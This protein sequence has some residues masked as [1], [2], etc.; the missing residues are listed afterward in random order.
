MEWRAR[1][2]ARVQ[3]IATG[4]RRAGSRADFADFVEYVERHHVVEVERL[5]KLLRAIEED[6]VPGLPDCPVHPEETLLLREICLDERGLALEFQ[7]LVVEFQ[8]FTILVNDNFCGLIGV[9]DGVIPPTGGRPGPSD[10]KIL[11]LANC[12]V[13]GKRSV[14]VEAEP[15]I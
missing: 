15:K 7:E 14:P 9:P 13:K 10:Q 4:C 3:T 1:Q 6:V 12:L 5:L 2:T 8:A 11:L